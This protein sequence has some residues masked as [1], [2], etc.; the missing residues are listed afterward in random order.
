MISS[1]MKARFRRETERKLGRLSEQLRPRKDG[2]SNVD[3]LH[4]VRSWYK[5]HI[6]AQKEWDK[7][8]RNGVSNRNHFPKL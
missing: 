6:F 2:R 7:V 3:F 5:A 4:S 1:N 8:R